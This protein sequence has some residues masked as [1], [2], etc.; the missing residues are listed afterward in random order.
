MHKD[1][2]KSIPKFF[3]RQAGAKTCIFVVPM[4]DCQRAEL[5]SANVAA[6]Q[7]VVFPASMAIRSSTVRQCE[8]GTFRAEVDAVGGFGLV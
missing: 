3:S 7:Y 1:T 6:G 8:A 5:Y 2:A 4:K